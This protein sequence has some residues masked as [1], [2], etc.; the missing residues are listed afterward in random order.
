[1]VAQ[2]GFCT[3]MGNFGFMICHDRQTGSGADGEM[4]RRGEI[5][6]GGFGIVG[7]R[8]EEKKKNEAG[9]GSCLKRV[10]AHTN[11]PTRHTEVAD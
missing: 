9:K 5:G 6:G 3:H 1:M 11:N 8:R 2:R 7:K 4:W 10:P